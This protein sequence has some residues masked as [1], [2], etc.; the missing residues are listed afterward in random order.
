MATYAL[1]LRVSK[2]SARIN[3]QL[4]LFFT[5]EGFQPPPHLCAQKWYNI[6]INVL[7]Y[8]FENNDAAHV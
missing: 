7:L 4:N 3:T 2:S 1:V 5:K 8:D 6:C